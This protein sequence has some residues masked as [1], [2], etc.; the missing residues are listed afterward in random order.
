MTRRLTLFAALVA[1]AA[2][3]PGCGGGGFVGQSQELVEVKG[4][5]TVQ[6]KSADR[7]TMTLTPVEPGKGREDVCAVTNGEYVT[8]VIAGKYKV[9]FEPNTGGTS[10]LRQY[11]SAASTPFEVDA[12][13]DAE[14]NFDLK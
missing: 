11:R 4:K 2:L 6:G 7:V 3:L 10:I 12:T 14:K 9:S 8:K 5:V 1:G 13:R